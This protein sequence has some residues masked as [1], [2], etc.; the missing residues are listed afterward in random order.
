MKPFILLLS[1][2]LSVL[3]FAQTP[4]IMHKRLGGTN[5]NYL[6]VLEHE[7]S[8]IRQSNFGLPPTIHVKR[9]VIDSIIAVNESTVVVVTSH[10]VRQEHQW[11]N[12]AY[13]TL[14]NTFYCPDSMIQKSLSYDSTGLWKP[15]RDTLINHPV[16]SA[17]LGCDQILA[18]LR[19]DYQLYGATEN[20][21][22]VGFNC[23]QHLH[24]TKKNDTPFWLTFLPS[25]PGKWLWMAFAISSIYGV[26]I[27]LSSVKKSV[28]SA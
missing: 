4:K 10:R 7:H 2:I 21:V 26:L 17:S 5:E 27:A 3:T 8:P 15:G 6:S 23:T 20:V 18:K 11:E 19:E 25:D 22:F 13:D 16:F 1:C 28:Y 9:A 12:L 14:S 24:R